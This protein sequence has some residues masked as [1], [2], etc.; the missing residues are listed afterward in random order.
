MSTSA[1]PYPVPTGRLHELLGGWSGEGTLQST[2]WAGL[3]AVHAEDDTPLAEREWTELDVTRRAHRVLLERLQPHLT[4]WPTR[5]N[6]WSNALPAVTQARRVTAARPLRPTEWAQT[7]RRFGWPPTA[8]IGRQRT[9]QADEL[10]L[11]TLRWTLPR[12]LTTFRH[13][14]A[15]LADA[16]MAVQPQA[17][18]AQR[19]LDEYVGLE[20]A[21]APSDADVLAVA[22]A[23]YP[24]NVL[25]P[26]TG[27]YLR[28]ERHLE[29]LASDL[30]YPL[31]SLRWRLFH[32][33]VL[34]EVLGAMRDAG[35]HLRWR[36]PLSAT[37]G[38]R[39][40]YT[41]VL[42]QAGDASAL[43]VWFEAAGVW[44]RYGTKYPY[45]EAL[46]A[47]SLRPGSIG[48][49]ILVL[50][51]EHRRALVLE[52]KYGDAKYVGRNG[53]LQA[54]AYAN[55][56]RVELADAIW[57][58]IVG[59]E[60]VVNGSS[61]TMLHEPHSAQR[62]GVTSPSGLRQIVIDFLQETTPATP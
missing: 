36:A 14:N 47:L 58:Y 11:A 7:T 33:G 38:G 6:D 61:H 27:T 45:R 15:V 35:A 43:E 23:G 54:V 46:R 62:L 18:A 41:A 21:P 42:P 50:D 30:I 34:G 19:L 4:R 53:Y 28:Y 12:M 29:D 52:C 59:P 17:A 51:L 1:E 56:L 9:T 44:S 25:A 37:T 5:L 32:I 24:W 3:A 31:D 16:A 22:R 26:V 40:Q 10:L 8:F 48:P 57:S 2:V 60:G 49:D 20:E 55:E 13:A 39:A